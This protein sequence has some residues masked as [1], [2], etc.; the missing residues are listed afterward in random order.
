MILPFMSVA[1]KGAMRWVVCMLMALAALTVCVHAH[2][3]SGPRKPSEDLKAKSH[4][5]PPE[6]WVHKVRAVRV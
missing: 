6:P 1:M 5:T 4:K 3:G 2:G